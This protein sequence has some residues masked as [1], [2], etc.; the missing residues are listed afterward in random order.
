V[1]RET[2][3]LLEFV[4]RTKWSWIESNGGDIVKHIGGC[5]G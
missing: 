2:Y 5:T 3:E 4:E 1:T